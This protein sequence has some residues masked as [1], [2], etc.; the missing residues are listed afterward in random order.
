[1]LPASLQTRACAC[2]HMKHFEEAVRPSSEHA[3]IPSLSFIAMGL[4]DAGAAG[5]S[6]STAPVLRAPASEASVGHLVGRCGRR[7]AFVLAERGESYSE[8]SFFLFYILMKRR[9]AYMTCTGV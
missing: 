2:T 8:S 6:V 9:T 4:R 1:M 7:L 5:V 3:Q